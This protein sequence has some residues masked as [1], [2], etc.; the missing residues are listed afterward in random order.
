MTYPAIVR[1]VVARWLQA[2]QAS[3]ARGKTKKLTQ[4][5]N[6]PRGIAPKVRK[7]QG[8]QPDEGHE[9]VTKENRRDIKPKDVFSP[10]PNHNSVVNLVETGND[11]SKPLNKQVPKDKG[12]D[13]ASNL[14]QY[15]IRTEGGGGAKP[16]GE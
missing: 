14:S 1:R 10:T 8:E 9:E 4:P 11:L 16:A 13:A 7:Q 3:G 2:D 5:I 12:Y 15:L 6:P